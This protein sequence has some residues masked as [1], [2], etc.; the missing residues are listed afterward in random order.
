MRRWT[1]PPIEV[2][3]RA[4]GEPFTRA[5]LIFYGVGHSGPSYEAL[6]F[7]NNPRAEIETARAAENGYAGSFVI[8]G[9]GGCYG[10]VG[11]C[12]IVQLPADPFDVRPPH[13]LEPWTLTVI[14]TEALGLVTTPELT[15][16]LVPVV[17]GETDSR[18]S[19]VLELAHVRLATYLE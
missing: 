3:E 7:L 12:D 10:D 14:V 1:S 19:D 4:A 9:H 2:P 5:D 13:A 16:T 6:I 8:F 11:H 18:G 15:V 17:P